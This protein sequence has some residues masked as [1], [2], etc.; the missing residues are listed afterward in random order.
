M[1]KI[2]RTIT[3]LTFYCLLLILTACDDFA[4]TNIRKQIDE[5]AWA[6][7]A[8]AVRVFPNVLAGSGVITPSGV[9]VSGEAYLAKQH[10]GFDVSYNMTN[11]AYAFIRWEAREGDVRGVNYDGSGGGAGALLPNQFLIQPDSE[12]P[13]NARIIS[14]LGGGSVTLTPVVVPRPWVMSFQPDGGTS[15]PAVLTTPV[16]IQFSLPIRLSS[17][18][19]GWSGG[20]VV[21]RQSTTE[22]PDG[23]FKNISITGR[24]TF[25]AGDSEPFEKYYNDPVLDDSGTI[26]TFTV[27]KNLMED[28][29]AFFSYI[30]VDLAAGIEA[31]GTD[32]VTL[33]TDAHF[34]YAVTDEKDIT[35]PVVTLV[36]ASASKEALTL[37]DP[38][39]P[40]SDETNYANIGAGSI[41]YLIVAAYD[42]IDK[43][44]LS[45]MTLNWRQTGGSTSY[46]RH[47]VSAYYF[48][49]R[50]N[51]PDYA[52][53]Q[54]EVEDK[55]GKLPGVMYVIP[56][57]PSPIPADAAG[58]FEIVPEVRDMSDNP[59]QLV[60]KL[61]LAVITPPT[62]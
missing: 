13:T 24:G 14:H 42:A 47:D 7:N 52:K 27:N 15:N 18:S 56:L 10:I 31:E 40:A 8:P 22:K 36:K 39:L 33:G 12:R 19:Y 37:I 44:A 25:G 50:Y 2:F 5:D 21:W 16:V 11:N 4:G 23:A 58:A 6:A 57:S 20:K 49:N 51:S 30:Y 35:G 3:L 32:A 41:V 55:Y 54:K 59:S 38:A 53:L 1:T 45:G 29:S 17:I 60:K 9:G 28:G 43:T 26:L 48:I 46:T 61:S 62:P 34:Q